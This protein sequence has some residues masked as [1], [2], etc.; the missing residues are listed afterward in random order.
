[1]NSSLV[2]TAKRI[3]SPSGST[4]R[5]LMGLALLFFV[6]AGVFA[7]RSFP[8]EALE[9][10]NWWLL[11]A[12]G[13]LGPLITIGLNAWEFQVQGRSLG[14]QISRPDAL[15]IS[16]MSTAA[17]LL[18]LPGAVVVRGKR[19]AQGGSTLRDI[20]SITIGSGLV[21]IG[22]TAVACSVGLALLQG[23]AFAGLVLGCGVV[24]ASVGLRVFSKPTTAR[25]ETGAQLIA[26]ESTLAVVS[27]GRMF[28]IVIGLGIQIS[29]GQALALGIS[30][31]LASAAGVFPAGLGV[32]EALAAGI[33]SLVDL[34]ASVG[35]TATA[36]DRVAGLVILALVTG[37]LVLTART[38]EPSQIEATGRSTSGRAKSE[39]L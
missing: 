22:C 4:R 11:G 23:W 7:V 34:P 21:W 5:A 18:P 29:A 2:E 33:A 16:V 20:S 17:N 25:F 1:M 19:L 9:R 36:A 30:G 28:F 24:A 27:A 32:R 38:D 3:R 35:Y 39:Q 12:V 13:I 6:V 31:A 14:Q 10:A 37:L 26:V 15:Q 8:R